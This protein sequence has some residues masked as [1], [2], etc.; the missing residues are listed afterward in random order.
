MN[1]KN[2]DVSSPLVDDHRTKVN[3]TETAAAEAAEAA[4]W[5][6]VFV[7][8]RDVLLFRRAFQDRSI[9]ELY[10][11]YCQHHKESDV[12]CFFV[13]ACLIAIHSAVNV[14]CCPD[15]ADVPL[16]SI[17]LALVSAGVAVT[18]V[19]LGLC[20]RRWRQHRTERASTVV[21]TATYTAWLL[22]NIIIL[23]LLHFEPTVSQWSLTWLLLVNFL[24]CVTLPI[25]LLTCL[26]FTTTTGLLFVVLSAWNVSTNP[27]FQQFTQQPIIQQVV[28]W[29][30]FLSSKLPFFPPFFG[31]KTLELPIEIF[32]FFPNS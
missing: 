32:H 1:S 27:T 11:R 25:R 30:H 8:L 7:P 24:T 15:D 31:T 17:L 21:L 28:S 13:A 29:R 26:I 2:G 3:A 20:I 18:Q 14:T 19:L 23:A 12:D 16:R 6:N 22:V 10:Q 9:E 4:K 5:R